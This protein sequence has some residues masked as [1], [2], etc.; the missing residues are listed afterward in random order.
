MSEA[1]IPQLRRQAQ[2]FVAHRPARL[3]E[4]GRSKD[5]D[6]FD[7]PRAQGGLE[8]LDGDRLADVVIH[9]GL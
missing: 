6:T 7:G 4:G 3:I 8:S 1:L 5:L 9:P 2:L